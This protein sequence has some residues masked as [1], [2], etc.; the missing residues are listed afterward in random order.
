MTIC[1]GQSWWL[2]QSKELKMLRGATPSLRRRRLLIWGTTSPLVSF[3]GLS[4]ANLQWLMRF[5]REESWGSAVGLWYLSGYVGWS[6]GWKMLKLG[7]YLIIIVN[8]HRLIM[9]HEPANPIGQLHLV[10]I[11][12]WTPKVEGPAMHSP[13]R[14]TVSESVYQSGG[15][16]S[17]TWLLKGVRATHAH[18]VHSL[19][20]RRQRSRAGK[21]GS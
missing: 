5:R 4:K 10:S 6:P 12:V 13:T 11:P 20:T 3:V 9:R 21:R 17:V 8:D 15:A 18:L 16:A 14:S 19:E 1:C 7:R 2:W